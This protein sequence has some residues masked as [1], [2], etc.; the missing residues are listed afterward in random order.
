MFYGANLCSSLL[1]C[2]ALFGDL[3]GAFAALCLQECH[4]FTIFPS[5]PQTELPDVEAKG[6]AKGRRGVNKYHCPL[7]VLISAGGSTSPCRF[8]SL[9]LFSGMILTGTV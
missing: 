9:F 3:S 4:F 5:T 2:R 1:L 6:Q 7:A 8:S